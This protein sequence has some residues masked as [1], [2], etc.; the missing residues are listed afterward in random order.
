MYSVGQLEILWE[1]IGSPFTILL[2]TDGSSFT[3]H[4]TYSVDETKTVFT[5][6]YGK[7]ARYIRLEIP[8]EHFISLFEFR[9]F[10]ATQQDIELGK[11]ELTN[12]ALN[13][14]V[15]ASQSQMDNPAS[16]AVDGKA[17]TRWGADYSGNAWLQVD[18]GG[19]KNIKALDIYFES[20]WNTYKVEYSSDGTNYTILCTGKKDE[21]TVSRSELNINARYVRVS[22]DGEGWFSI[23]ELEVYG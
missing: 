23:I 1:S 13:K 3:K 20:A 2:S 5:N 6:L 21:L 9:A 16:G 19:V 18:L 11:N 15:T 17:E 10:E 12:L 8:S 14:T 7:Q 22:R 4:K